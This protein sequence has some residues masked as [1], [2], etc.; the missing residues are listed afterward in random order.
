MGY[1]AR[2]TGIKIES[3]HFLR[4]PCLS[5]AERSVLHKYTYIG[6]LDMQ[7]TSTQSNVTEF[8]TRIRARTKF[9]YLGIFT[10]RFLFYFILFL[11]RGCRINHV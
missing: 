1:H 4:P 3:S 6:I 2:P 10:G 11:T 7:T 5:P 8:V 9:I